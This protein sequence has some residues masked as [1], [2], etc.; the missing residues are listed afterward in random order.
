[1]NARATVALLALAVACA[2]PAPVAPAPAPAPEATPSP[3]ARRPEPPHPVPLPAN[4][5]QLGKIP[6]SGYVGAIHWWR[7]SAEQIAVYTEIYRWAGE[8]VRRAAA[9]ERSGAWGVI[10][11]A[12]ETLLDN[13]D[14][15]LE[16][17]GQGLDY[18]SE[19]WAA[20]VHRQAARATPGSVE[21]TRLVH[22]LGGRVAVVTNR[23]DELCPDTRENLRRLGI[24]FDVVLCRVNHVDD[25]NPRFR[26]VQS[27]TDTGLPAL[28]VL[29]WVGDNV[30]DFPDQSQAIRAQGP[31]A[32]SRF[33][34]TFVA[35]PNPMY[36]SW[37]NNPVQ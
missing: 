13:S 1:M 21:F 9:G 4:P 36:G 7:N 11:D 19:S 20:W 29:M 30:N 28:H 18:T 10:M 16:R 22:G 15:Q 2:R 27:G 25:K 26:Q 5:P 34:S 14:Y 31:D 33:G 23:D 24:T 8:T 17:N 3:A 37:T 6:P 32:F 12:D 35:L